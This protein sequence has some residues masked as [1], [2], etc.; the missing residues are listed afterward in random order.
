MQSNRNQSE[1]GLMDRLPV[2]SVRGYGIALFVKQKFSVS[3]FFQIYF[4][5]QLN[6]VF[7]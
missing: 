5:Y 2:K 1:R 6:A 7:K 4:R 3:F